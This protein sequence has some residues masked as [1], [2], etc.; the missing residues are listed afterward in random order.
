MSRSRLSNC[1][2]TGSR[3][4]DGALRTHGF[5]GEGV[6]GPSVIAVKF[7]SIN[8]LFTNMKKLPKRIPPTVPVFGA[9][10]VLIRN[11]R[12]SLVAEWHREKSKRQS[13]V[14]VS[15]HFLYVGKEYFGMSTLST[16]VTPLVKDTIITIVVSAGQNPD[17]RDYVTR[18]TDR[19]K[20][21]ICGWLINGYNNP[22]HIIA[23]ESLK[24]NKSYEMFKA[25]EFLGGKKLSLEYI[26]S[27]IS[28]DYNKFYR[29]HTDSFEHYSPDQEK[30][31]SQIVLDTINLLK[32]HYHYKS[33]IFEI[34]N[35]Y[36]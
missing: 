1:N 13:N 30:Y 33:R 25:L 19:W 36:I 23:Y 26:S 9:A 12:D 31:I 2:F 22:I 21:H 27:K 10:I 17:W 5:N 3:Y 32:V 18:M 15:N 7:H 34:L 6:Y 28:L 4:C 8:P 29:N 14:N 11:P 20:R 16:F 35:S 24:A